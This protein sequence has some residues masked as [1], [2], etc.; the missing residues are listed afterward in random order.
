MAT[1]DFG[2]YA[3]GRRAQVHA[4]EGRP[5]TVA[6]DGSGALLGAVGGVPYLILSLPVGALIDRWDRKRVMILCDA[7]RALT[8][9]S[10]PVALWL[11]H[12]TVAQLYIVALIHGILFV[13]F[14]LAGVA[15]LPR[16]VPKHQLPTTMAQNQIAA[17]GAG[18]LGP[19][20]GGY[21]YQ[22]GRALPF[23]SDAL[24]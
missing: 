20:L 18:L 22:L 19:S 1:G 10:I 5:G 9:G 14:S 23:L 4:A 2:Q 16:V 7:G 24:S 13:Y 11:A 17:Y 6:G 8:L 3:G 15:A 12:L 21:L